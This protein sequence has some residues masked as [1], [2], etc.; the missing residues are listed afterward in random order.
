MPV[1]HAM[2]IL[3]RQIDNWQNE[4]LPQRVGNFKHRVLP[5]DVT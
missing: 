5:D 3:L 4:C 1:S 2:G